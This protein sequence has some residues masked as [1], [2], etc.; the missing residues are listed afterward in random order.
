MT[1]RLPISSATNPRLKALRRLRRRGSADAFLAEGYRQLAHALDAEAEVRELYSAPALHLGA[2]EAAI[3]AEAA[4][5]GVEVVELGAA[6][7]RSVA[8]P[9][10]PDG[11]LGVIGRWSTDLA[12]LRLGPDPLVVVAEAVE[13]PGNLGTIVRSACAAGAQALVACDGRVSLFHP[14]T[15]QGAVGAIFHMPVATAPTPD[16]VAW[17]RRL[18]IRIVVAAPQARTPHW[19]AHLTGAVAVVV[20]NERSGLSE[21]WL[22]ASDAAVSIPMGA[23]ADSLNVAVA[24]GVVLFEA[25]RQRSIAAGVSSA[26]E[27]STTSAS[28]SAAASGGNDGLGIATT[29]IPAARALRMPLCESSTAAQRSGRTSSRRAASR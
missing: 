19:R 11:L 4:L 10:R 6:A 26:S 15:V 24:A 14:E 16:A 27:R 3:V 13:R 8:G 21:R 17:L 18:G 28:S 1:R 29:R 5:R 20:G 7:F 22:D 9:A 23:G 12:R 25:V 2:A